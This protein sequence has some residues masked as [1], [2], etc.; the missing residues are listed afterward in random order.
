[1]KKKTKTLVNYMS[2]FKRFLIFLRER[3]HLDYSH[4]KDKI[5]KWIS[6]LAR[7]SKEEEEEKLERQTRKLSIFG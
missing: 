5:G 7:L 2:T 6:S 1:M 4:L 3:T